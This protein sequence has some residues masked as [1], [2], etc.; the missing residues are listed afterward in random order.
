MARRLL[1]KD[2][3][4]LIAYQ[5][6]AAMLVGTA[7]RVAGCRVRLVHQTTLPSELSPLQRRLDHWAGW[8]GLYTHNVANT[9]ETL[10]QFEGHALP[11][12]RALVLIEHGVAVPAPSRGRSAT[13]RAFG[14]PD[15]GPILLNVGRLTAQKNQAVVIRALPALPSARL[16]IAGG[17]P[18]LAEWRAMAAALGVASRV[19]FLGDVEASEIANLYGAA[20]LFV[21]PSTW[22]SFG[23]AAVEAAMSGLPLVV[24]DL[25]VLREVLSAVGDAASFVDRRDVAG[26]EAALKAALARGRPSPAAA[27]AMQSRYALS[28]MIDDYARLLARALAQGE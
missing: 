14:V 23:L 16:V 28:R 2:Y 8:L 9:G 12:R 1:A 17:G 25:P 6:T 15:D 5:P 26:L 24:S 7:G 11:Y 3:D 4:A 27:R 20:D 18:Q 22:E 13:L 19:H 10:R 21:F